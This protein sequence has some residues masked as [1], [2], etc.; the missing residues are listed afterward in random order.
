MFNYTVYSFESGKWVTLA[1]I[2]HP[3]NS[4]LHNNLAE[5]A[6]YKY[7]IQAWDSSGN[8]SPNSSEV[9]FYLT[10]ITP[11]SIPSNFGAAIVGFDDA[12]N[13]TWTQ[14]IDDTVNYSI[15]WQHPVTSLW[16]EIANITHPKDFFVFRHALLVDDGV[17]HFKIRAID[18]VGLDSGFSLPV[19]VTHDDQLPPQP[20]VGLIAVT[21]SSSEIGLGW[22]ASPDDDVEWYRVLRNATGGGATGP[23]VA[24]VEIKTFSYTVT[25]LLAYTTY[26]F[27]LLCLDEA[28]NPSADSNVASNTTFAVA[29]A[30]PNMDDLPDYTND[31]TLNVTGTTELGTTVLVY[32]GTTQTASGDEDGSG[33]FRIEIKLSEGANEIT[34]RA[35][36]TAMLLSELSDAQT[37]IL[38]TAAP[39]AKAGADIALKKGGTASFN[40]S[41]ST[42]NYG[43][44]NY[45]WSFEYGSRATVV[46]YGMGNM[47]VFDDIGEYEV[48]LTVTDLADNTGTDKLWVNVTS[49]VVRPKVVTT[50]PEDEDTDVSIDTSVTITFDIAM[51]TV[52]VKDTLSIS[53]A[54]D[55]TLNWSDGNTTV[56]IIFDDSLDYNTTY[57]ITI[58]DAKATTGGIL[59]D[60]PIVFSFTTEEEPVLPPPTPTLSI[61]PITVTKIEPGDSITI[62]GTTTDIGSGTEVDVTIDGTS[63]KGTVAADGTWTV[64][65][66]VLDTPG[67]YTVTVTIGELTKTETIT[68]SEPEKEPEKETEDRNAL[69]AGLGIVIII[70][71]AALAL[72]FLRR[73]KP[74]EGEE[75]LEEEGESESVGEEESIEE[76]EEEEEGESVGEVEEEVEEEVAEEEETIEEEAEEEEEEPVEE[77]AEEE[78]VEEEEIEDVSALQTMACPKCGTE[79]EVPESDEPKVSLH[80]PACGAK[81]KIKNPYL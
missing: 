12:I 56:T 19:E 40:A 2:L 72:L 1:N 38:D 55:H 34:V 47:F 45:S 59:Q 52:S 33:N 4:T 20:P 65:I 49:P 57:E 81:G 9:N 70:I 71:L 74:A 27:V 50:D 77:E 13:I 21:A 3:Q 26:Y 15:F 28:S 37:V 14:N 42:D 69:Y 61:S 66:K 68:V 73:R 79:I 48:T 41:A 58:G 53:P 6:L 32:I 44:A 64:S 18:D 31:P 11:P 35:R 25:N 67:T 30:K 76:E 8:P 43:I 63:V 54:V 60:A 75:P 16:V 78:E 24:V 80:C 29:P 46:L 5:E 51:D 36:N 62:S 39:K 22:T 23:W 7:K 10:D 17:Y